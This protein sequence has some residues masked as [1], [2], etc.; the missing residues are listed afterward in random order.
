MLQST[1]QIGYSMIVAVMLVVADEFE[2][3]CA[4]Y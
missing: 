2:C 3:V 4:S 1:N